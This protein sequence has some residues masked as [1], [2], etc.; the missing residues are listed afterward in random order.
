ML[1]AKCPFGSRRASVLESLV[2]R[3]LVRI[4][5]ELD[6]PPILGKTSLSAAL[7]RLVELTSGKVLI[8]DVNISRLG[9]HELR[10]AI[11]IIPQDPV[12]F[13]GSLRFNLDPFN[14]FSLDE[15][16]DALDKAHISVSFPLSR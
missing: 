5:P 1:Y 3:A 11:T 14:E 10:R 4:F 9:L 15:I 8:D 2:E 13:S 16:W 7:F 12:L 6:S